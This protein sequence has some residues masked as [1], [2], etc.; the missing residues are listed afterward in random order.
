MS[1]EAITSYIAK[2]PQPQ[3]RILSKIR[4]LITD[5]FPTA[6]ELMSY[7][8]PAFKLNK[9]VFMYAAFKNHIGIYPDPTTIEFFKNKLTSYETSKGTIK[10]KITK[11]IPYDLI[12]EIVNYKF[13]KK[14]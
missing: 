11:P 7:G 1:N 13:T 8:V 4:K 10:F 2:Q 14:S 6:I 9:A 3:Q 12:K 5:L